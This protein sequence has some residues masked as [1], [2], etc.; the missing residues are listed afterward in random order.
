MSEQQNPEPTAPR[1]AQRSE[2]PTVAP[3]PISLTKTDPLGHMSDGLAADLHKLDAQE[4]RPTG[5]KKHGKRTAKA[6]VYGGL[7]VTV[8]VEPWLLL[9]IVPAL[10]LALR[11]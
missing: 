6:A 4:A 5:K 1:S 10:W 3:G 11:D 8:L 9:F 7:G 2:V